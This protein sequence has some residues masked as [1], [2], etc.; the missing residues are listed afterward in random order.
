LPGAGLEGGVLGHIL[1]DSEVRLQ[2]TVVV[3][4][5]PWHGLSNSSE[6]RGF[7]KYRGSSNVTTVTLAVALTILPWAGDSGLLFGGVFARFVNGALSGLD[8][9]ACQEGDG[10][11]EGVAGDFAG[12]LNKALYV[13]VR[14]LLKL[15][16]GVAHEVNSSERRF[17]R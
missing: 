5:D 3:D 7:G 10:A 11:L 1:G 2:S 6:A 13:E 14:D 9:S 16:A 15:V 12:E 8:V 17:S 4:E